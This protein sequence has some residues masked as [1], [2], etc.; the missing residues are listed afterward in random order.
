MPGCNLSFGEVQ[1][2][3]EVALFIS[4][5]LTKNG[6]KLEDVLFAFERLIKVNQ[7]YRKEEDADIEE[8]ND[9][10]AFTRKVLEAAATVDK[11]GRESNPCGTGS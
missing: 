6:G 8:E 11:E 3:L 5:Y 4:D 7:Q 9:K 10:I 2:A 1:V